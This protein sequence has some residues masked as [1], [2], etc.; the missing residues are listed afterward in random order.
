MAF[1]GIWAFD[2]ASDNISVFPG[3]IKYEL[4]CLPYRAY[5]WMMSV[6]VKVICS[7]EISLVDEVDVSVVM[8]PSIL[9][10]FTADAVFS[11]QFVKTVQ[12]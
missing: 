5:V 7:S 11:S 8:N 12:Q 4:R 2:G 10:K 6:K 3:V 9:V 1:N